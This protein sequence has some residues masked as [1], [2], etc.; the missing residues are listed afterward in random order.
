M[1]VD[2]QD[3]NFI[4]KLDACK[5]ISVA[6]SV[7]FT[8]FMQFNDAICILNIEINELYEY[9]PSSINALITALTSGDSRS[10]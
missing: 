4:H 6:S 1:Q 3:F 9:T 7:I 10:F 8:E 5:L 2:Y